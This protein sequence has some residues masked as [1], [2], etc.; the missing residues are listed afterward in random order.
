MPV[1]TPA[2]E[3]W[4]MRR[5]HRSTR[6]RWSRYLR[7]TMGQRLASLPPWLKAMLLLLF[8]AAGLLTV[9]SVLADGTP[10][11]P[12]YAPGSVV[13]ISGDNSDGAGYLP[14]ETVH[15]DVSGP[16]GYTASCAAVPGGKCGVVCAVI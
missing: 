6:D 12:D 10:D 5:T 9:S 11:K 14:G 4:D 2:E 3:G 7:P 13:T 16:N 1:A 15:V 8:L